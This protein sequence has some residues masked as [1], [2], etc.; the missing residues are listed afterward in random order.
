MKLLNQKTCLQ[1]QGG[2]CERV[3]KEGSQ[4]ILYVCDSMDDTNEGIKLGFAAR[5]EH[6]KPV[7]VVFKD[8]NYPHQ[9]RDIEI[10]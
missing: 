10:A 7:R 5:R 1:V 4:K 8:E 9:K 2:V 3:D 6:H